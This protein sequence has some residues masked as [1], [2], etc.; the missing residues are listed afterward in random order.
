MGRRKISFDPPAKTFGLLGLIVMKVSLCGP[1]SLDT[2][3]LPFAVVDELDNGLASPPLSR[4]N[5]YLLHHVGLFGSF[6]ALTVRRLYMKRLA[7]I[8][9]NTPAINRCF[10]AMSFSL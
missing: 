5:S 7:I 8:K 2:S 3:T 10:F 6:C 1:H 9:P 4:M